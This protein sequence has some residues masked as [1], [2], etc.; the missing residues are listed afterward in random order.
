[1]DWKCYAFED[2]NYGLQ[3]MRQWDALIDRHQATMYSVP[4][5]SP[6]PA[7]Y[8]ELVRDARGHP[9]GGDPR[10]QGDDDADADGA[11]HLAFGHAQGRARGRGVVAVQPPRVAG[12]HGRPARLA[13]D[14]LFEGALGYIPQTP[15]EA[16]GQ[17]GLEARETSGDFIERPGPAV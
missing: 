14:Y 15:Q 17:D 10:H 6:R 4:W 9:V 8:A 12:G 3:M 11:V 7:N 2:S 1:M 16:V 13:R 5:L